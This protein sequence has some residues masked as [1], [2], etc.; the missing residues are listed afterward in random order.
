MTATDIPE[1]QWLL[2]D[3]KRIMTA[4]DVKKNE[5]SVHTFQSCKKQAP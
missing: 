1:V 4:T 2:G 5:V 3:G